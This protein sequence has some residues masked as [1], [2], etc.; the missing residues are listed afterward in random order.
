[1][2]LKILTRWTS[3]KLSVEQIELFVYTGYITRE[4][5]EVIKA[6]PIT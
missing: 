6:T 2:Y 3:N 4:E 1:M 5:A